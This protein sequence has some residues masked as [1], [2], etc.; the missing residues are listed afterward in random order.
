M[1][2]KRPR[3]RSSR[4]WSDQVNSLKCLTITVK[5][6]RPEGQTHNRMEGFNKKRYEETRILTRHS[7]IKKTIKSV[8]IIIIVKPLLA[9]YRAQVRMRRI[10][11]VISNHAGQVQI[12]RLHALFRMACRFLHDVF[13]HR[14]SN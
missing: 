1:E 3:G 9:Y 13:L 5:T 10:K 6:K 12:G 2:G 8:I 14:Y 4:R 7:V 11:A